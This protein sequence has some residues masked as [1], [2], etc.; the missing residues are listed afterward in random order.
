MCALTRR[1]IFLVF[2]S[3]TSQDSYTADV[4]HLLEYIQPV[5]VSRNF[6]ASRYIIV[7]IGT[8][9]AGYTFINVLQRAA[10]DFSAK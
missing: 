10:N 1:G 8:S 6:V 7:L 3:N 2:V 4:R 5:P 9:L